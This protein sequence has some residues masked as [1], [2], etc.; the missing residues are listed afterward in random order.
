M[1]QYYKPYIKRGDEE[2]ILYSWDY[3]SGLKL[4][5]HS[6][7]GNQFVN[8]VYTLIENEPAKVGWIGDY[9]DDVGVDEG[10]Y[11]KVWGTDNNCTKV[12]PKD[13]F[14]SPN[15]EH[16]GRGYLLNNTKYEYIDLA[17]YYDL[18]K[19]SFK[20]SDGEDWWCVNPLP[21][22]TAIGNGQGG[23][24]YYEDYPNFNMVGY[25]YLDEIEYCT[26]YYPTDFADIT[27]DVIFQEV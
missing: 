16:I 9:S 6:W 13:F 17:K 2:F 3:G 14:K 12:E 24:D 10:L 25:W 15:G 21:L 19:F 4:M 8:A 11:K 22:L 23:G 18:A 7:I 5:E 1:G 27:E 26:D 20:Y